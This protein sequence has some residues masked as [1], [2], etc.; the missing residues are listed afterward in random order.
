MLNPRVGMKIYDNVW[1]TRFRLEAEQAADVLAGM[2]VTYVMAQ[3]KILPMQDTAIESEVTEAEAARF[4]TLD[5]RAFRDALAA[6][7]IAYFAS[8]NIGFDPAFISAHPNLLPL[9][10]SGRREEKVDWYIGLPPDRM[11]NIDQKIGMIE[12]AV[13]ALM[14]DGVHLGFIRWP[15][16]WEVW[17]PDVRRED[18]PDYC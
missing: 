11:A 5:D 4:A 18:M 9:D 15:G 3:S 7:G 17:L 12:P 6:R 14:P 1:Y 13:R 10:Q 2:G 16:L 8:I